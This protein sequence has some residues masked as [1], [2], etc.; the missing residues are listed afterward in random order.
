MRLIILLFLVISFNAYSQNNLG[1]TDDISRISIS[2][3][4]PDQIDGLTENVKESL[5]NKLNL[6]ITN[7]SLAGTFNSRFILTPYISVESKEIT[8]TSPSM[9]LLVLNLYFYVGDVY[10][11]IK[12]ASTAIRLK[13][14]GTNETKAY[15]AA[16]KG[17]NIDN[18]KF[19][20][21]I[22]KSKNKI[23]EYYNGRCDFN[24]KKAQTLAGMDNFEEAIANLTQVP[25]VC[26]SCYDKT[27][28]AALPIYKSLINKKCKSDLNNAQNI[29]A[30]GQDLNSAEQVSKIL[31]QM[32]PNALCYAEVQ[33]LVSIITKRVK[34]LDNREWSFKLKQQQDEVDIRKASIYALREIGLTYANN[35]P[36]VVYNT[37]VIR[38]WW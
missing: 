32:D 14:V 13:G 28:D 1:N 37:N 9:I 23:I 18:P 22:D 12:F 36:K 31:S 8:S 25:E 11:G 20:D 2:P 35:Q 17:L 30:G 6:I 29:W 15:L 26:K 3:F 4:I 10:E 33:K 34:E 7:N 27:M 5:L 24:I 21:L 19:K 16:L 38:T